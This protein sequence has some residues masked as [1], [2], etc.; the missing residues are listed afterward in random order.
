MLPF[1]ATAVHAC[2]F[3]VLGQPALRSQDANRLPGR[4]LLEDHMLC[5][6]M[7]AANDKQDEDLVYKR[8][9]SGGWLLAVFK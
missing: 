5:G 1:G 8:H 7:D 6:D 9:L 2:V 3:H 4:R